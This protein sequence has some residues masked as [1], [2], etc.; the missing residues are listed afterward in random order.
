[1]SPITAIVLG[2]GNRGANAYGSYGLDHPNELDIVA[3]ADPDVERRTRMATAHDIEP[4]LQFETWEAA[5]ARPKLAQVAFITTQD[6]MHVGPTIAAL[7]AGY[8]V[9]LEKPMATSPADCALLVET[10]ERLGR[11]LQICHVLRY[12]NFFSTLYDIIRS[13]R[14]GEIVSI[15]H[16]ENVA[17]YHMAHSFVRGNWGVEADSNPMILAKCCHDLDI[18]LWIMGQKVA[19]LTSYGSLFHFRPQAAPAGA[20]LRCQGDGNGVCPA[21]ATCMFYAPRL[22]NAEPQNAVPSDFTFTA[23][24]FMLNALGGGNSPQSRWDKLKT[25]Q[26]GRCVYHCDNDV[27][28]RQVIALEF[29]NGVPCTFTMHGHS[30]R[31]NRTMRWDG[32]K[33][34]LYA[35]FG[36]AEFQEIRICDHGGMYHTVKEEVIVPP[37]A[38][39]GHGGGDHGLVRDFLLAVQGQPSPRQTTARASLESHLLAFAAE[40]S[41][42]SGSSID[43][44]A[45]KNQVVQI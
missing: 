41:R 32:T 34:T 3:V 40:A 19:K 24:G 31:E 18:L 25:S 20:T 15:D 35:E 33:A 39:S 45:Y 7:E 28:D 14:L 12:T 9:L 43:F 16:R 2:A 10:A 30:D 22:Y 36:Y 23:S 27:V 37:P 13:G 26:Y 44:A 38:G 17:W 6:N 11:T 1:M 29:E 8:D 42:K 5:L 21:A 4:D